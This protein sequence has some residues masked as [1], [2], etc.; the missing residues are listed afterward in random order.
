MNPR[1]AFL[2]LI[3][4]VAFG[5]IGSLPTS[6]STLTCPSGGIGTTISNSG[7]TLTYTSAGTPTC[8]PFGNGNP[9]NGGGSDPVNSLGY[10]TLDT[11]SSV[12]PLTLTMT[13]GATSGTF[14]FTTTGYQDF[15]LGFQGG[16]ANTN[17]DYFSFYLP[18]D[19]TSGSWAINST[20]GK[21]LSLGL[22]Y[23]HTAAVG[24]TPAPAAL[25]L[26]ATGLGALGL[27]GWRRKRKKAATLAA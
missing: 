22:L 11:T 20:N 7:V 25:P 23:G 1:G 15:V 13:T 4:G 16:T 24:E 6:A 27:L 3:T 18:S 2:A 26:F 17:P 12:G 9:L 14:S 19:V 10:L 8:G 5:V 21:T